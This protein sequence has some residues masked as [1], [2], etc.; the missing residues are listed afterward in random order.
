MIS[1]F[2]Q[3]FEFWCKFLCSTCKIKYA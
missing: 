2:I 1:Y 3:N